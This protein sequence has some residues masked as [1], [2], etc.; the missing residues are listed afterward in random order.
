MSASTFADLKFKVESSSM[1]LVNAGDPTFIIRGPGEIWQDETGALQFKIFAEREPYH[2]L[3]NYMGRPGIIGQPIPDR[4]FFNLRA[5]TYG[6]PTWTAERIMPAPR[7]GFTD[8]MAHG[9][10]NELIHHA[11]ADPG[12]EFDQVVVRFKGILEFP[13]NRFT[14]T[15]RRI[16][17][18]V[19]GTSM[20][21]DAAHFQAD[22]FRFEITRE[23]EHTQV[24]L[25]LPVGEYNQTTPNRIREALQFVLGRELTLL[26]IESLSSTG[27][28]T[29]LISPF[30]GRGTGEVAPPLQLT[31]TDPSD[32]FWRMFGNYFQFIHRDHTSPMHPV[33]CQ[34]HSSIESAAA[35]LD[36]EVLGLAVAVEGLIGGCFS[37]LATVSEQ[38]LRDLDDADRFLSTAPIAGQVR[39]RIRGFIPSM[40]RPRSADALRAFISS[41]QLHPGLYR[42][43]SRLRNASAHGAGIGSNDYANILR[44]KNETLALFYAIVL[45]AINYAG[46]RTDYSLPGHPR[47][48]WPISTSATN[49]PVT[50]RPNENPPASEGHR[51]ILLWQKIRS[52]IDDWVHRTFTTR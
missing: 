47:G 52:L 29:R 46:P 7:G 25:L 22:R 13:A 20:S 21:R 16:G 11:D 2:R 39:D 35:S 9:Y 27:R 38:F 26:T 14:E 37:G 43:W 3:R 49:L 18:Q 17:E 4:E 8:G 1:E 30:F 5:V 34:I 6:M 19:R 51:M 10:I 41:Q 36:A 44:I 31:H 23:S 50:V 42:S 15:E 24:L 33:S 45:A 48:Q 40:R 12:G 28:Y 32:D